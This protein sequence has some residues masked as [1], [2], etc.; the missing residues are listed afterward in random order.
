MRIVLRRYFTVVPFHRIPAAVSA[1]LLGVACVATIQ[2]V[3]PQSVTADAAMSDQQYLAEST[4]AM[5]AMMQAM[6][7]SPRG[8]ADSDF[9]AQMVPHHQGAIAMAEAL[10]RHGKDPRLRRLAQEIIVT[11]RDEIAVMRVVAGAQ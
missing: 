8:D 1:L 6:S 4:S 5:E 10:L 9:V 2:K 7:N 3:R 11:Q